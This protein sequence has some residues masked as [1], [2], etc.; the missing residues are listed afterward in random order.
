[1]ELLSA[2]GTAEEYLAQIARDAG[3][4][5]RS[6]LPLGDSLPEQGMVGAYRLIRRIGA[7]GMGEVFLA[8]RADGQFEMR[9]A[10][11][12]LSR[13]P[14]YRA[15]EGRFL[16]ERQIL[17]SFGHPGI[18]RLLD[19]GVTASGIP[20]IVMEYVDGEPVD[21]YCARVGASLEDRLAC[22]IEVCEAVDYAHQRG[23]I[24]RDLKTS[25][26]LVTP[27]GRVKLLDFGI[28]KVLHEEADLELTRGDA[29]SPLTL[30]WASPEQAEDGRVRF[31][32]DVYQLGLI[33]YR[34][35]TGRAP[36]PLSGLSPREARERIASRD[37]VP[38]SRSIQRGREEGDGPG[39]LP[40]AGTVVDL[41]EALAGPVDRIIL[42]ALERDPAR[43]Y[44]HA[45][46][47]GADLR[48]CLEGKVAVV[49]GGRSVRR[50]LAG[51]IGTL[52][53]LAA[54]GLAFFHLV[55][56]DA[57]GGTAPGALPVVAV[58][59]FQ[60]MGDAD[61]GDWGHL[62]AT[63]LGSALDGT[64]L[65]RLADPRLVLA[66]VE[67]TEA[68]R[69]NRDAF[70][71]ASVGADHFLSGSIQF[72]GDR[73][74]IRASLHPTR[75]PEQE[76]AVSVREGMSNSVQEL[77]GDLSVDML[78]ALLPDLPVRWAGSGTTSMPALKRFL[79]GE[80]EY[81]SGRYRT[82]L[83]LFQEAIALDS[84]YALAY[85]RQSLATEWGGL[86]API[87]PARQA[88]ALRDRLPWLEGQM[89]QA[90]IFYREQRNDEAERL[91]RNI[92]RHD[93]NSVEGWYQLGEIHF[94]RGPPRGV[95]I[96]ASRQAYERALQLDP[97]HIQSMVHLARL[98]ALEGREEEL[99]GLVV[100]YGTHAS[101]DEGRLLELELLLALLRD[102][103]A[104]MERL[105]AQ[106]EHETDNRRWLIAARGA[107][108]SNNL[109]GALFLLSPLFEPGHEGRIQAAAHFL[110]MQ[111]ELARGRIDEAESRQARIAGLSLAGAALAQAQIAL[112]PSFPPDPSRL[113]IARQLLL[114]WGAEVGLRPGIAHALFENPSPANQGT[115]A[116]YLSRVALAQDDLR[117]AH[118]WRAVLDT[119]SHPSASEYG[120]EIQARFAWRDDGAQ[121]ALE[122]LEAGGSVVG[123]PYTSASPVTLPQ[124]D[125]R[126]LRAVLL[127]ELGRGDESEAWLESLV[128]D[129][130]FAI[131][132]LP[133]VRAAAR[134]ASR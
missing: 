47:L 6:D 64:H 110:A 127:A 9:V 92:L 1:M 112:H 38:P 21:V 81:R 44:P 70:V 17:A 128:E 126:H 129:Y 45:G 23:V 22:M 52:A 69:E 117:E 25:N 13:G 131:A 122:I 86:G 82:A 7:G 89:V 12:L 99:A 15:L 35:V 130:A 80:L 84:T 39:D 46:A 103:W 123:L 78:E 29:R 94:H 33:L 100:R 28:A 119:V 41:P 73:A 124:L 90:H 36:I 34:L 75:E 56:R 105:N 97:G 67:S 118:L 83:G 26:I 68:G 120:R 37:P 66:A 61:P 14:R 43:R 98:A 57:D 111:I 30:G 54:M 101:A 133:M 31:P 16:A 91:L 10:I 77:L 85:Y 49:A 71:A 109:E 95:G 79:E 18:A 55:E 121:R 60:V 93:P 104:E 50:Q 132:F 106:L 3:A 88:L 96:L 125:A 27:E 42:K 116:Y 62:S 76:L 59:P 72:A 32:S 2:S 115:R 40:G 108:F 58:L 87:G 102:D 107:L 20:Y 63:E 5:F 51:L 48:A 65:L 74:W 24:H 4:L 19:G 8:E 11:K 113:A 134:H 114:D 53:V